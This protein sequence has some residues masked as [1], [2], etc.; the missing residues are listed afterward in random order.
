M[1]LHELHLILCHKRVWTTSQWAPKIVNYHLEPKR[2]KNEPF[3]FFVCNFFPF[4]SSSTFIAV[5]ITKH[6]VFPSIKLWK[7]IKSK[8]F[9]LW[10]SLLTI[11]TWFLLNSFSRT[12]I[13]EKYPTSVNFSHDGKN[14]FKTCGLDLFLWNYKFD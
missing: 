4:F 2:A 13:Q 7:I 12:Q 8:Q 3:H 6:N 5:N 14:V 11:H 10:L 9:F 1:Y